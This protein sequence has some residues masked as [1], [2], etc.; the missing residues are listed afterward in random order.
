M[1]LELEISALAPLVQI[2]SVRAASDA[3]EE[4]LAA[5]RDSRSG[6]AI[7]GTFDGSRAA[8]ESAVPIVSGSFGARIEAVWAEADDQVDCKTD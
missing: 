1:Q 5:I 4:F 3:I 8:F 2:R 6:G 7:G